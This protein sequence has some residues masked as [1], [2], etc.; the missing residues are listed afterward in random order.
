MREN[1]KQQTRNSCQKTHDKEDSGK[2]V[3]VFDKH[4]RKTKQ[5][6]MITDEVSSRK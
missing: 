6:E 3:K 5:T 1:R 4:G 2:G